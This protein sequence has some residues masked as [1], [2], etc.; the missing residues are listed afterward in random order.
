MMLLPALRPDP[1]LHSPSLDTFGLA[2]ACFA[3]NLCSQG[4]SGPEWITGSGL[5]DR[6]RLLGDVARSPVG[7]MFHA[8]LRSAAGAAEVNSRVRSCSFG[9]DNEATPRVA[10]SN[11]HSA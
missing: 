5:P 1:V 3:P 4:R 9:R 2:R 10:L 6:Q 11:C 8:A 7:T